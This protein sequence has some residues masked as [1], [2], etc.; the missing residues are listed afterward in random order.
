M[1]IGAD[2]GYGNSKLDIWTTENN[3]TDANP[4]SLSLIWPS[5]SKRKFYVGNVMF[6][7]SSRREK[8][9]SV[10]FYITVNKSMTMAAFYG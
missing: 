6:T 5:G 1:E 9:T 8:R 10:R 4:K 2:R 7:S 3:V